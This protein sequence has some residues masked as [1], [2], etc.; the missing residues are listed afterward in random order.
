MDGFD[1]QAEAPG[2]VDPVRLL[3][4]RYRAAFISVAVLVL[5][6]SLVIQP[7]L[8]RLTSDAPVINIAGRQRMLSQRLAKAALER[9]RDPADQARLLNE[10]E[11]VLDLW[12]STHAALRRDA[13]PSSL[14][15]YNKNHSNDRHNNTDNTDD[16]NTIRSAFDG[17]EPYFQPMNKAGMRLLRGTDGA[18]GDDIS[19]ILDNEPEY[20]SRMDHIV[21]LF[22]RQARAKID[23]LV[24]TGWGVTGLVLV[25]MAGIGGFILEPA[26]RLIRRQFA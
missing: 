20:L 7:S 1:S 4:R 5:L 10:L 12:S 8:L 16:N 23:R 21:G 26:A 22:E 13:A 24:W 18:A 14:P 19:T 6:N 3:N 15:I 9:A 2:T 17:L 25:V 11:Q